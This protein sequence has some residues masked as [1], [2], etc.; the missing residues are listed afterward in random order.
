[1]RAKRGVRD[2]GEEGAEDREAGVP[3]R[4]G[5]WAASG[6]SRTKTAAGPVLG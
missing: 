4:S 1:M 5:W 6:K 2:L 3:E